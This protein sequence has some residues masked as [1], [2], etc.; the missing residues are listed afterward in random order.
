MKNLNLKH[1]MKFYMKSREL[2]NHFYGYQIDTSLK[3]LVGKI[4]EVSKYR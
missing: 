2:M 3:N 1:Y 4:T